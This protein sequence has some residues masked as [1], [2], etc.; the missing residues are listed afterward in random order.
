MVVPF[1]AQGACA[2]LQERKEGLTGKLETV[3]TLPAAAEAR[4]G[5]L[6]EDIYRR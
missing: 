4:E 3:E 2:Q 6:K 5:S 1:R